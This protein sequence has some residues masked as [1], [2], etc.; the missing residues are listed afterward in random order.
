MVKGKFMIADFQSYTFWLIVISLFCLLLERI[1]PW[2][3]QKL[4]RPQWLQDVFWLAFNGYFLAVLFAPL[5]TG[6]AGLADQL[7]ARIG[8]PQPS[9]VNLLNS[10]PFWM[11]FFVLLVVQD[12]IEWSVHNALHRIPALWEF[13]KVHHSIHD[14]DWI[15]NFRFHWMEVLIYKPAKYLPLAFMG[16]NYEPVLAVAVFATLVGH[17]N[18]SNVPFDYGPLKYIFNS[19]KMHIWHH[20]TEL[21]LNSGQNFGIVLSVWDWLFGTAWMPQGQPQR[22]GFDGD[23]KFPDNLLLRMIYPASKFLMAHEE[24]K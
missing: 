5:F 16:F 24:S 2:R 11:Q 19:P 6:A 22:L 17:L 7:F 15:G 8:W 13:H 23:D 14:M 18:H 20:D 1:I 21:H 4:L 12:F 10:Q 9:Q 3:Q